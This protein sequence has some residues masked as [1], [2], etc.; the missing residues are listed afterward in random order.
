LTAPARVL[1]R[2]ILRDIHRFWFGELR[3]PGDHRE[4]RTAIWYEQSDETDR[5]IRERFGGFIPEAAATDWDVGSLSREEGIALVVLL[6]Q[7]PRN[8]FRSA[9]EAFA[10]DSR[11]RE[12]ARAL[13][14]TGIGRFFWVER[15]ALVLPFEHSEE[16]ADQDY[17]VML[18]AELAVGAPE[19]LRELCRDTLDYATRH[20]DIIRKFGRFPHRNAL[21]GRESTAVEVAFMAE[22][23]RGY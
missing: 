11:A 10:Y 1:D 20:R 14:A 12:I 7:F 9:G 6:D 8:L 15:I 3:S 4:E 5:E 21:L 22:R 23:G 2:S 18:A 19:N 16:M 13:L 17:A